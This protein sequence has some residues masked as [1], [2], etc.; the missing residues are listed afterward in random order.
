MYVHSS[1]ALSSLQHFHPF[2]ESQHCF[3]ALYPLVIYF[4]FLSYLFPSILG[5]HSE[6]FLHV[7]SLHSK[8]LSF[9]LAS[10]VPTHRACP[11]PSSPCFL[12]SYLSVL[13]LLSSV[14]PNSCLPLKSSLPPSL[15]SFPAILHSILSSPPFKPYF[16][17]KDCDK[18]GQQG[19][20]LSPTRLSSECLSSTLTAPPHSRSGQRSERSRFPSHL[21]HFLAVYPG[22]H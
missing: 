5:G 14:H 13:S 3:Y 12:S 17:L 9:F 10:F 1:C 2:P 11:P 6:H 7:Y 15:P 20:D 21:H 19:T 16:A 22:T 4:S 8:H 18:P